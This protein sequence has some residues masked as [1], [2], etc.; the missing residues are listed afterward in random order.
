MVSIVRH[1]FAVLLAAALSPILVGLVAAL[2]RGPREFGA[3]RLPIFVE[4]DTM[5]LGALF[6]G[7]PLTL[8]G[9]VIYLVLSIRWEL[10]GRIAA[11]SGFLIAA[12]VS[13]VASLPA[14]FVAAGE[15]E[16]WLSVIGPVLAFGLYGAA[17]GLVFWL[18]LA[19]PR[20][21]SVARRLALPSALTAI[22]I[23][24]LFSTHA[25]IQDRSC[26]N[27]SRTGLTSVSPELDLFIGVEEREW[28]DVSNVLEDF[29]QARRWSFGKSHVNDTPGFRALDISLCTE[30]GTNIY[31]LGRRYP[32]PGI[33]P[34][35]SKLS[36]Q[37]YQPQG[38]DDWMAPAKDLTTIL[39]K[40]W[41]GRLEFWKGG[42][43]IPP[44]DWLG[45]SA[46]VE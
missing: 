24:S 3:E 7:L 33:L 28:E 42:Y 40:R 17:G 8:I 38:G 11:L 12:S 16:A 15:P 35:G 37:V 32:E 36:M 4:P 34:W 5:F 30:P 6:V 41:P 18:V 22:A 44:P 26:H 20:E 46:E 25:L 23:A 13:L 29:A 14:I 1:L 21:G 9:F 10:S 19:V 43:V 31:L 2:V 39:A 45:L 27:M